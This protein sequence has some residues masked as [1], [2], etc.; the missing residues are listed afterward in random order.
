MMLATFALGGMLD[1]HEMNGL[2]TVLAVAVNA[3]ALAE[4]IIKGVVAWGPGLIMMAGAIIGGYFGAL[5]ARKIDPRWV[6][7]LV[8]VTGWTMT[9]YFFVR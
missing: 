1:I 8:V 6:R 3:L 7:T 4:F 2:K 9:L 5:L